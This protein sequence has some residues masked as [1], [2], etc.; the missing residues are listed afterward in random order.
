MPKKVLG[1]DIGTSSIKICELGSTLKG[2]KATK[3]YEKGLPRSGPGESRKEIVINALKE[4]KEDYALGGETVI[5]AIPGYLATARTLTLPFRDKKK[6]S[7]IIK[8]EL[9][10]NIPYPIDEVVVDFHL[11][12][13]NTK[14]SSALAWA[15]PKKVISE[16]LAILEAVDWEPASLEL[17]YLSLANI[18]LKLYPNITEK[19]QVAL[20]DI[21]A[22]KTSVLIMG[23]KNLEF[24]RSFIKAGDFFTELISKDLNL[25]LNDAEEA[26]IRGE[27][28]IESSLERGFSL[29]QKEIEHTF[30]A[31]SSLF[32]RDL[33]LEEVFFTGGGAKLKGLL[34]FMA[35]AFKMKTTLFLPSS[36]ILF[37][38]PA[39]QK[40]LLDSLAVSTGL[41]LRGLSSLPIQLNL[42]KEEFTPPGQ[43]REF[44]NRAAFIAIPLIILALLFVFNA[45]QKIQMKE[46]RYKVLRNQIRSVFTQTFPDINNIVSEIDQL[47]A[48]LKEEQAKATAY[49]GS[50]GAQLSALDLLRELSSR[51][52]KDTKV[53]VSEL[54]VDQ[55]AVRLSGETDSF[56]SVDNLK[57]GLE[58][59]P[60]FKEVKIN[61]AKVGTSEKI[62]EFRI[63]IFLKSIEKGSL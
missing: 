44:K 15:I 5:S 27:A 25:P 6:I 38:G 2:F 3:C 53:D 56:D 59:S 11:I 24:A 62:V 46:E 29:L 12:S 58:R 21:G 13:E 42:R 7:H 55:D 17:D 47:K 14:G 9:E 19:K 45:Y 60:Y 51:I 50:I 36:E 43:D 41:A 20:I 40:E 32:S 39:N 26:K 4:L 23:H 57:K 10:P 49:G 31:A 1:L 54:I 18:F 28:S 52:S 37:S 34:E 8:F 22:S 35:N 61:N 30:L 33:A 63:S 48:K 16:H